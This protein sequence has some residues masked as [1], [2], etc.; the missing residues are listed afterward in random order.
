MRKILIKGS[1]AVVSAAATVAIPLALGAVFPVTA[2]AAA[3]PVA[4]SVSD[5]GTVTYYKNIEQALTAGYGGKEIY[6]NG[7][8]NLTSHLNIADS[9]SITINLNGYSIAHTGSS[10]DYVIRVCEHAKV[11]FKGGES[12]S[13]SYLGYDSDGTAAAMQ[14]TSGGLITGGNSSIYSGGIRLDAHCDVTLDGIALAG[15]YGDDGGGAYFK[16]QL[17]TLTLKNAQVTGNKSGEDGGGLDVESTRSTLKMVSS[18]VYGNFAKEDGGGVYSG[19]NENKFYFDGNSH[20]DS[21]TAGRSG[22]GLY[23]NY[24][25]FDVISE[26]KGA[27]ISNN[28]A[29]ATEA[30]EGGG[31]L[32]I[33]HSAVTH[34]DGLIKGITFSGNQAPDGYGGG[35]YV[36]Q[37]RIQ[38]TDCSFTGNTAYAGGGMYLDNDDTALKNCTI[39][40]NKL[41]TSTRYDR[42]SSKKGGGVFVD[43]EVDV[44]LSGKIIVT[45]NT[46][47]DGTANNMFLANMRYHDYEY[48]WAYAVGTVDKDSQIGV[49]APVRFDTKRRFAKGITN[50]VEGTYFLDND[51]PDPDFWET[52][53]G[54]HIVYEDGELWKDQDKYQYLVT[55][56]GEST[57]RYDANTQVLV[58]GASADAN[59]VFKCWVKEGSSGFVFKDTIKDVYNPLVYLTVHTNDIHLEAEYATRLKSAQL[60]IA[61]PVAG[62]ELPTT[63]TLQWTDADSSARPYSDVTVVWYEVASDG[64][65]ALASGVAKANATYIASVTA[66]ENIELGQVFSKDLSAQDVTVLMGKANATKAASASVDA[67]TGV[68]TILTS[69][70]TTAKAKVSRV[71][72]AGVSVRPGITAD[73]LKA[74]IPDTATA[75]LEDDGKVSLAVDKDKISW[76][77]GLFDED[78]KLVMPA[79]ASQLYR[80]NVPLLATEDVDLNG[81]SNMTAVVRVA[82]LGAET[83][84][85]PVLELDEEQAQGSSVV[86]KASCSTTGAIIKYRVDDGDE[87]A[88]D[89]ATGIVLNGESGKQSAHAVV[90]WAEKDGA[91]SSEVSQTFVVKAISTA[92]VK[93]EELATP[94]NTGSG[95][96]DEPVIYEFTTGGPATIVAPQVQGVSFDHWEWA[97]APQGFDATSQTITIDKL[98]ADIELTACYKTVISTLELGIDAPVAGKE[99]ACNTATLN[100]TLS[101]SASLDLFKLIGVPAGEKL[102]VSWTPGEND[103]SAQEKADYSTVYTAVFDFGAYSEAIDMTDLL[104]KSLAIKANGAQVAGAAAN[105]AEQD[106]EYY[107][108]VTFPATSAPKVTSVDF[109]NEIQLS[110]EEAAAGKWALPKS[111]AVK[112]ESGESTVADIV[113]DEP[114]SFDADAA[115]GQVFT[116]E[117]TLESS[118]NYD[119]SSIVLEAVFY[120]DAPVNATAAKAVKGKTVKV[121]ANK[122]SKKTKKAKSVTIKAPASSTGTSAKFK[123]L[124]KSAK[125]KAKNGK[126][127]LKKGAKKGK[128]YKAK[129]LV[130]YGKFAKV[131]TVKFKV[132]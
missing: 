2:M 84:N 5:N 97:D 46:S 51:E 6:L 128:T 71:W 117:G 40:G 1:A 102:G 64:T 43:A 70:Q 82:L 121:K 123:T 74:Q 105:F 69:S 53:E 95:V 94:L 130:S 24:T 31:G 28:R 111:A 107:L 88:Y 86:V 27:T 120:V 32:Y 7:N 113:W 17:A 118:S 59:K 36:D 72:D 100:A 101:D 114:T 124:S 55:I 119:G 39:T 127:T 35:V 85:A 96:P 125:I 73:E 19:S 30:G 42:N 22:G 14:V 122:S 8:W 129:V 57:K 78:G 108:L 45:D 112:L 47:A 66:Q 16:G 92:T 49:T 77:Q 99:L 63:A 104:S 3:N 26:G 75:E 12:K 4:Y 37:E 13:L 98:D 23:L 33:D 67:D 126:V 90:A 34:D 89:D 60:T 109:V 80:I 15:N 81:K 48:Q 50:Y 11:T 132:K 68:V 115:D 41:V 9:K 110:F 20:I 65:R 25:F 10:K 106:G 52:G 38:F 93:C 44:Q 21:N 61:A 29:L 56:N 131:V 87:Q 83:V 116:V 79:D 58:N 62:K 76:P 91:V 18:S 103:S 54:F